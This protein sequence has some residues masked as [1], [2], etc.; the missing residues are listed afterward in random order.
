MSGRSRDE[1]PPEP[2]QLH[3]WDAGG[4]EV[5]IGELEDDGG[6][7]TLHVVLEQAAPDLYRGRLSFRRGE[8][9]VETAPVIV[10]DSEEAVVRRATG[11]PPSMV[12]QFFLSVRD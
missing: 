3:I 12:R 2:P 11:L 1:Q 4:R 6:D 9:R 10:E 7:W 8:E 5:Q